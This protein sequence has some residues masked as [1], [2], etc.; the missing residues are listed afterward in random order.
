ML[1]SLFMKVLFHIVVDV[2]IWLVYF[3]I[4]EGIT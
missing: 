3:N 4:D 1:L 2:V